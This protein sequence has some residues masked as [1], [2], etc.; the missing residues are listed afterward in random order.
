[1]EPQEHRLVQVTVNEDGT[2][3][4]HVLDAANFFDFATYQFLFP[5]LELREGMTFRLSG[6]D[7]LGRQ[8]EI[9]PVKVMGKTRVADAGGQMHNVRRVD[10]MFEARIGS[11]TPE[12]VAPCFPD[13]PP[14]QIGH[15]PHA[16]RSVLGSRAPDRQVTSS[17]WSF[18]T[19]GSRRSWA[20]QRGGAWNRPGAGRTIEAYR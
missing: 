14:R 12:P 13:V 16:Q 7:Y 20:M 6:Y 2:T 3:G 18:G 8:A 9:L 10:I 17:C 5:F 19:Y 4:T 11:S 15:R 1:M